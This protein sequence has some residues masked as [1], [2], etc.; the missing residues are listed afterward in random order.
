MVSTLSPWTARLQELVQH[1]P[2]SYDRAI[3]EM[4]ALVPPGRAYRDGK[5]QK[6]W[7]RRRHNVTK[8]KAVSADYEKK[9]AISSGALRLARVAV[10]TQQRDGRVVIEGEGADRVIRPGP[11][12]IGEVSA[13]ATGVRP[14]PRPSLS[15]MRPVSREVWRAVAERPISMGDLRARVAHLVP[16]GESS[17]RAYVTETLHSMVRRRRVSAEGSLGDDATMVSAGPD[18][19]TSPPPKPEK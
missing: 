11:N 12:P 15:R 16:K 5:R 10:W 8:F 19:W 17:P 7:G 2:V 3:A 13:R 6:D 18:F 14:R 9:A 1:G 4:A